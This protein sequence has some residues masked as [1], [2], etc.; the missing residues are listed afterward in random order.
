MMTGPAFHDFLIRGANDRLLTDRN[1]DIIDAN[2][3]FFVHF[4]NEN[5]RKKSSVRDRTILAIPYDVG[6]PDA[7]RLPSCA[8]E[9]I[10]HVVENDRPYTE[11]LT[12]DYIMANPFAA[13]AY[14][15]STSVQ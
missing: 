8:L 9:L 13:R 6:E 14:G 11:I 1:T 12:A 4:T 2:R 10:A 7:T 3:G 5:T 15:A